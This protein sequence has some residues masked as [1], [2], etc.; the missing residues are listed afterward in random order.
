MIE[1]SFQLD[2][3]LLRSGFNYKNITDIFNNLNITFIRRIRKTQINYE[4]K[5][6]EDIQ[7]KYN[8]CAFSVLSGNSDCVYLC[9][10]LDRSAK[11][12]LKILKLKAFL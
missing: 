2:E 8:G 6:L 9:F 7:Q 1:H 11:E 12:L 10:V 5:R 3:L 4:L